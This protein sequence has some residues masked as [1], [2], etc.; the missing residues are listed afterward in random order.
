MIVK[1]WTRSM[2]CGVKLKRLKAY[3]PHLRN[4][5]HTDKDGSVV[6]VETDGRTG[7]PVQTGEVGNSDEQI[8]RRTDATKYIISLNAWIITVIYCGVPKELRNFQT[9]VT[10]TTVAMA[11]KNLPRAHKTPKI[12]YGVLSGGA[13]VRTRIVVMDYSYHGDHSVAMATKEEPWDSQNSTTCNWQCCKPT[14]KA[15]VWIYNLYVYLQEMVTMLAMVCSVHQW[16]VCTW[17][18]SG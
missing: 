8:N 3:R 16:K 6:R 10:L 1:L 17:Y 7:Q 5:S 4:Y 2:A 14:N 15:L 9:L 11:T 12:L 18:Q 13:L